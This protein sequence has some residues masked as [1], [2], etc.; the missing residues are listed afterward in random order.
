ML[1]GI[2]RK[3]QCSPQGY[4]L[5]PVNEGLICAIAVWSRRGIRPKEAIG[6]RYN[7]FVEIRR[8][9][10]VRWLKIGREI[11]AWEITVRLCRGIIAPPDYLIQLVSA[12]AA[13]WNWVW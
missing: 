13:I 6:I 8:S 2:R 1:K 10:R 7:V 9:S 11:A 3:T 12:A 4:E 5:L